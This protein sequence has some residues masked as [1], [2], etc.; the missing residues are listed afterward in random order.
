MPAQ[1]VLRKGDGM[2]L[3]EM[4]V[5]FAT[6]AQSLNLTESSPK[7]VP[8]LC[9]VFLLLLFPWQ[10]GQILSSV[11]EFQAIASKKEMDSPKY[12]SSHRISQRTLSVL[13]VLFS[14]VHD[15]VI[16]IQHL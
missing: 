2:S 1:P 12:L 14:I 6:C 3:Q 13:K 11:H 16:T 7:Q 9:L 15:W 8:S 5:L 4:R 10:L